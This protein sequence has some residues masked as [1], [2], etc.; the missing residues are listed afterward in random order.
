MIQ[1]HSNSSVSVV[2]SCLFLLFLIVNVDINVLCKRVPARVATV[3]GSKGNTTVTDDNTTINN[4]QASTFSKSNQ[5]QVDGLN[6][7]IQ[8]YNAVDE[9]KIR[10]EADASFPKTNDARKPRSVSS[11]WCDSEDQCSRSLCPWRERFDFDRARSPMILKYAECLSTNCNYN[12]GSLDQNVQSVLNFYTIC[13]VIRT[14]KWSK[15]DDR[16]ISSN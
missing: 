13:D 1:N 11:L 5:H 6:S 3:E 9:L 12:F 15:T 7:T 14:G 16:P 10:L 2:K 4:S 8:N